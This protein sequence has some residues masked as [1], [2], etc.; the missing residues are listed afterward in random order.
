MIRNDSDHGKSAK[1]VGEV[2]QCL[3]ANHAESGSELSY[4][5]DLVLVPLTMEMNEV[6]FVCCLV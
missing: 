3:V 4:Y 2:I 1:V 5:R 6:L